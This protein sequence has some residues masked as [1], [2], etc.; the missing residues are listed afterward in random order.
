[1]AMVETGFFFP[2][3]V[4]LLEWLQGH[5]GGAGIMIFQFFS[6]FGEELLLALGLGAVY[7]SFQKKLGKT[8]GI[9]VLNAVVWGSMC[10]DIVLRRRPYIDHESIKILRPTNPEADLYDSVAQGY[11][12]PSGH[13][14]NSASLFGSLALGLKKGWLT[15]LAIIIPLGTGISRLVLGA[16]YPT[17]VLGGWALGMISVFLVSFLERKIKNPLL[18]DGLFILILLPGFFYCRGS[19]FYT[20]AGLL[21]GFILGCHFEERF[22]CFEDTRKPLAMILRLVGGLAVYMALNTLLKLPFSE[23]FLAGGSKASLLV[24][25]ARYMIVAFVD[26]G[27][28]PAVFGIGK[29]KRQEV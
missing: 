13:S 10:K 2:W 27:V 22:V 25:T 12:F 15:A 7:W 23:E 9:S 4:Q 18:L 28:Y 17:D 1:M 24:R 3:E 21:I 26:F 6:L 8:V 5:I 16:H 29:R 20:G 11:S 14:A 19:D